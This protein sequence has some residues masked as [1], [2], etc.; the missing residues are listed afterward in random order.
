MFVAPALHHVIGDMDNVAGGMAVAA[1]QRLQRM[2]EQIGGVDVDLHHAVD[3]CAQRNPRLL[4]HP[5]AGVMDDGAQ[6]VGV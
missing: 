3:H 2:V 6:T 5:V 1:Q 4:R